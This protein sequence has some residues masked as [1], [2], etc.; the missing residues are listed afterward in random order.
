MHRTSLKNAVHS[1]GLRSALH[2]HLQCTPIA[3]APHCVF[4]G[5]L[6]RCERSPTDSTDYTNL[7]RTLCGLRR[8]WD[9]GSPKEEE[10]GGCGLCGGDG[11]GTRLARITRSTRLKD[12]RRRG[13][14]GNRV[15][16]N[17]QSLWRLYGA[18]C[19]PCEGAMEIGWHSGSTDAEKATRREYPAMQPCMDGDVVRLS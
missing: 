11:K 16:A 5:G 6:P 12:E 14:E 8:G 18:K 4:R 13:C 3:I 19:L 17:Q 1:I 9:E 7:L 10:R 2:W 15:P